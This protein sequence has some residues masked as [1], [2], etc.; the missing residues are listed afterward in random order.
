M[1]KTA[2][3]N[4]LYESDFYEWTRQQAKLLRER[5][6]DDLDLENLV[7]EVQSVGISDKREIA[8]RLKVLLA[9]LLKWMFQP[10]IRNN[11][12][13]GTIHEQRSRIA[14]VLADS[15]SLKSYP[16]S[17]LVDEYDSARL[18]ASSETGIALDL[19]PET[20]P[21]TIEQALDMAYLPDEPGHIGC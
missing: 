21:F 13:S 16:A 8:S 17:V 4:D 6:W 9:H 18:L 19:F 1:T 10:G 20:C 7:E 3:S 2:I 14:R 12:W 15:P 5:R 11:S